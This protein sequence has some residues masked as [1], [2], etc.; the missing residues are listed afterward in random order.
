[1]INPSASR[2]PS[3]W[4][5]LIRLLSSPVANADSI[6]LGPNW[7]ASVMG[8]GIIA[9]GAM[10]LPVSF[11]GK[12]LLATIAWVLAAGLLVV[13]LVAVP[14]HWL[15]NLG[16]F[17]ALT[18]DPVLA[19]FFGAPPMAMMTVGLATL[20]VGSHYLGEDVA[21]TL[22]WVLWLSGT[23][24][25]VVVA[26]AIPYFLFTRIEVAKDGAFGGWLMPV[27]CPMVSAA[28]GA[29]LIS[30]LSSDQAQSTML[31][32]CYAMFG[33]SLVPAMIVITL[34]WSRLAHFGSSGTARVPTLWIVLGP[35]GQSITAVGTLATAAALVPGLALA[36]T[37]ESISIVF[38]VPMF[39]FMVL[40][41]ALALLLTIRAK[42]RN[43]GFALT[44]W[45]FT[46]PIGTCVTG[47][48]QL[49]KH[50]GLPFFTVVAVGLYLVLVAAW[51]YVL[52]HTS[53]GA[54]QGHLLAAVTP[55]PHAKASKDL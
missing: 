5:R 48:S 1:M 52:V 32:L 55:A 9:T 53:K 47:T 4:R 24:L 3:H 13:L 6:L 46:F 50:T 51:A 25:G 39:G 42:R 35:V 43:M 33:M 44:W 23:V 16:T 18:R 36:G 19:Q 7:F 10:A 54:W 8:T 31:M 28:S 27:V 38:G 15:R 30:H 2:Q 20:Q 37:L 14:V 29:A 22:D 17:T 11:P 12:L 21:V 40:W 26:I 45:S 41:M 34:I 49:A